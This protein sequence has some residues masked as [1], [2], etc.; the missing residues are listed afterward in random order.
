MVYDMGGVFGKCS[1][2][3]Q[4]SPSCG[5]QFMWEQRWPV[6]DQVCKAHRFTPGRPTSGKTTTFL[7]QAPGFFLSCSLSLAPDLCM[8]PGEVAA[9]NRHACL[10]VFHMQATAFE[11]NYPTFPK[12]GAWGNAPGYPS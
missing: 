4:L 2:R 5:Q 1:E 3:A 7:S 6:T 12:P 11:P 10:F 9:G 8:K